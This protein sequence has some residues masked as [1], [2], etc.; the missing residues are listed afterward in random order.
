M[1]LTFNQLE[2]D[3]VLVPALDRQ[4]LKGHLLSLTQQFEFLF[5]ILCFAICFLKEPVINTGSLL[6]PLLSWF[7][8]TSCPGQ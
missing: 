7:T 1:D 6:V 2:L 3:G 8:D 5:L 4:L